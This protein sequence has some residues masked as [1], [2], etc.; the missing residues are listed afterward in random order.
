MAQAVARVLNLVARSDPARAGAWADA[1]GRFTDLTASHL[2]YPAVSMAV[3][4]GVLE[5]ESGA[6]QP[7]RAV[8]GSEAIDAVE[9]LGRLAGSV[10]RR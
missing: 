2:A 8:T 10:S 1:R 3:A 7:T 5:A 9:R 6:F 4:A